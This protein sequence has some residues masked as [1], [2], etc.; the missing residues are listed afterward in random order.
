MSKISD[1]QQIFQN[2]NSYKMFTLS[3]MGHR[4]L[5][6]N[7]PPVPDFRNHLTIMIGISHLVSCLVNMDIYFN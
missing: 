4:S 5:S 6:V 7:K 2:S 3:L 1:I